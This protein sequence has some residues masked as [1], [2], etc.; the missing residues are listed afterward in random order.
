MRLKPNV[1]RD[2]IVYVGARIM[3]LAVDNH[4]SRLALKMACAL[5]HPRDDLQACMLH[6]ADPHALVQGCMPARSHATHR[7]NKG[8]RA[9]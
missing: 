7:L 8:N 9:S 2:K 3:V 1:C 6:R 4:A 5:M